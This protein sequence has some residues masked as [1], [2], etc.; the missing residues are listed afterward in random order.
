MKE[1]H[2]IITDQLEIH[3]VNDKIKKTSTPLFFI[4]ST[5][6]KRSGGKG[7]YNYYENELFDSNHLMLLK[8]TMD[9]NGVK[10]RF[11]TDVEFYAEYEKRI[12]S[13]V[14]ETEITDRLGQNRVIRFNNALPPSER[15]TPLLK[16]MKLLDQVDTLRACEYILKKEREFDRI[17]KIQS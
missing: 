3:L 16:F 7:L 11:T 5:W 4:K 1:L 17:L 2:Y 13:C 14:I 10:C 15:F 12:K 9:I 6:Y 8:K